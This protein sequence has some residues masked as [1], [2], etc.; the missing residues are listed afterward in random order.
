[1]ICLYVANASA[2]AVVVTVTSMLPTLPSLMEVL[3]LG[4]GAGTGGMMLPP[5]ES[6]TH[7]AATLS[8]GCEL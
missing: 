7:D 8:D 5:C 6:V 2:A 4:A 3:R 1:M